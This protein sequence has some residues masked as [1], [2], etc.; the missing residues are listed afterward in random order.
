MSVGQKSNNRTGTG[1]GPSQSEAHAQALDRLGAYWLHHLTRDSAIPLDVILE[2]G[3]REAR[4]AEE[5]VEVG[6]TRDV[7]ERHVGALIIPWHSVDGKT[8]IHQIKVRQ[9]R[10]GAQKYLLPKGLSP[11][12]HCRA[13]TRSLLDDTSVPLWITEGAKQTDAFGGLIVGLIGVW[14]FAVAGSK[15]RTL[16]PD[17]EHIALEGRRVIICY[18][19]DV[20]VKG[21]VQ[22]ALSRLVDRLTE[23]GADVKVVYLPDS[24]GRGVGLDDYMAAGGTYTELEQMP[25]PFKPVD[26]LKERL[27]RKPLLAHRIGLLAFKLKSEDWSMRSGDTQRDLYHALIYL[28]AMDGK[29]A[30]VGMRVKASQ[31]TLAEMVR[32]EHRTVGKNLKK[33]DE[34]GLVKTDRRG[35]PKRSSPVLVLPVDPARINPSIGKNRVSALPPFLY[36]GVNSRGPT[37]V[38]NSR[39]KKV[40]SGTALDGL[41][42]SERY[43]RPGKRVAEALSRVA[44]TETWSI[45]VDDLAFAMRVSRQRDLLRK[46][47]VVERMVGWG[48]AVVDDGVLSL[49]PDW[50]RRMDEI[51]VLTEEPEADNAQ[52]RRHEAERLAYAIGRLARAGQDA[53]T[54]A[55]TLRLPEDQVRRFL[56]PPDEE[57]P[58]MGPERVEEIV[59]EQDAEAERHRVEGER[60][61]VGTTAATVLSDE[62]ERV[63]AVRW[64]ELR[65]RWMEM[66]GDEEGLRLEIHRGPYA[67]FR[68]KDDGNRLYVRRVS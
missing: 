38:R 9:H 1:C 28:A 46:G 32:A 55:K 24:D 48:L 22:M 51:R 21:P 41:T 44:E 20:M 67:F 40:D 47:G 31:R 56:A 37:T 57:G 13:S 27:A 2:R 18:D 58:L 52:R 63:V 50:R 66:G 8:V 54:I 6:F 5:L 53:A 35:I 65:G 33:L 17:F 29:Q 12:V 25:E 34:R 45:R 62:T 7:A 64:A 26:V 36:S 30:D 42:F 4:S 43:E 59:R 10:R 19:S 3:Y 61:K 68:E 14:N 11:V 15:S 49:L 60:R 39:S 16:L 23:E